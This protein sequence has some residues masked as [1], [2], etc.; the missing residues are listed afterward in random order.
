MSK[1]EMNFEASLKSG[2]I[3]NFRRIKKYD[4]NRR[5]ERES[6]RS[7]RK[8]LYILLPIVGVVFAINQ[9]AGLAA[10]GIALLIAL[11]VLRKTH[12]GK[13]TVIETYTEGNMVPGMITSTDP[14][15][16]M[17]VSSLNTDEDHT[18]R[19]A[20]YKLVVEE[21]PD[22]KIQ[23][24]EKVPCAC[25]YRYEGGVYHS[26]M[27]AFPLCW[28]TDD[29]A[30]MNRVLAE[31]DRWN[32]EH[33]D[34]YEVIKRIAGEYPELKSRQMILMDE[35]YRP[36]SVKYYWEDNYRPFE[37]PV[38]R[39]HPKQYPGID[40]VT[41]PFP[42]ADFYNKM[43]ELAAETGVYEYITTKGQQPGGPITVLNTG[44]FTYMSDG[45]TFLEEV[46]NTGVSLAPDEYPLFCAKDVATTKGIWRK[47]KF[48]PW[49]K[50]EIQVDMEDTEEIRIKLEG[51]LS[52]K[53][54]MN[55][56]FFTEKNSFGKEDWNEVIKSE[57]QN[58]EVF[59]NHLVKLCMK[60]NMK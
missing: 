3:P 58:T 46:S 30:A 53:F 47:Q 54:P 23:L 34:E 36:I 14:L 10:A 42:A 44:F 41:D 60:I 59:L 21:L 31:F 40:P 24:Y 52:V 28:A 49:A 16:V 26:G 7:I 9:T 20:C 19:L 25:V 6:I 17:A 33:T 4:E 37:F 18:E 29:K 22:T 43:I 35:N 50:V 55:K 32:L 1:Y 8:V 45:I 5:A 2:V 56:E 15:T 39:L 48:I 57:Q 27:Q 51:V 11:F 13:K 12:I 38:S